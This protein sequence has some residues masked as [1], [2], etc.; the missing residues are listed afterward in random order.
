R[1]T[2]NS[3]RP[4]PVEGRSGDAPPSPKPDCTPAARS[5]IAP[6]SAALDLPIEQAR[7][8]LGAAN[9]GRLKRLGIETVRDALEYYPYRHRDF[10]RTV[11]ISALRPGIEQTVRGTIDR[12]REV[13]MGRGG[14]MRASEV[15]ITDELG[16]RI[17]ATWFNQPY[18]AKALPVGAE[19]ALSG[20]V[21]VFRG[22][23]G[24]Q[25]PEYELLDRR[26]EGQ[27]TGRLVPG[28]HLTQGLPQPT[29][30]QVIA[31]LVETYADRIEDPLPAAIRERLRLL[32]LAEATRQVHYPDTEESLHDARRRLAFDELLAIQLGVQARKREW[33]EGGDAPVVVDHEIADGFLE[34]LE[35]RLTAA[36]QRVLHELRGDLARPWPMSRLLEGDVGSGK[37]VVALAAMLSM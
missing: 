23:P 27:H 9:L 8:R 34:T 2:K 32:P 25:N 11:P 1:A 12:S 36:Q 10:S 6:G 13:R 35:F 31:N 3:V 26:A 37:T 17:T 18:I 28:Y 19:V 15:Q 22:R 14:R 24:F 4:E 7:T 16:S 29:L 21:T 30:R 20:K 5:K 33:R